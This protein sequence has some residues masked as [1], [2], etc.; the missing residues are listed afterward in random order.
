MCQ[1]LSLDTLC[2]E[3]A[4]KQS[5]IPRNGSQCG[6]VESDDSLRL[7]SLLSP[8]S[9]QVLHVIHGWLTAIK[10]ERIVQRVGGLDK[11]W[12]VRRARRCVHSG[13]PLGAEAVRMPPGHGC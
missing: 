11:R 4:P 6:Q 12:H 13:N 8:P 7:A 5:K 10:E 1:H 3:R 9:A 2:P